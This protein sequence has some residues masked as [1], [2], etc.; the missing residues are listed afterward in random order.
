MLTRATE[1]PWNLS[2]LSTIKTYFSLVS[3][4]DVGSTAACYPV[5]LS[6]LNLHLESMIPKVAAA[7]R[8]RVEGG[9]PVYWS[10]L[11][12]VHWPK[13]VAWPN[14]TAK[15]ENKRSTRRC[16]E[17]QCL[18][19]GRKQDER[20]L[21]YK[22]V[23]MEKKIKKKLDLLEGI[24]ETNSSLKTL[25]KRFW[26]SVNGKKCNNVLLGKTRCEWQVSICVNS[27]FGILD[28]SVSFSKRKTLYKV[29]LAVTTLFTFEI[30]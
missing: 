3:Q 19:Q 28:F 29:P 1:K 15:T 4:F 24:C 30:R 26:K 22:F 11:C 21:A 6:F 12:S 20:Q 18:H 27:S 8:G 7:G 10:L 25:A 9:T 23:W 5:P 14:L 2:G 13:V 16:G 17:L